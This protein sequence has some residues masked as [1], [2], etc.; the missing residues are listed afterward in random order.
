MTDHPN[1]NRRFYA[2]QSPRGFANEVMIRVFTTRQLRDVWVS[3]HQDDGDV[4][5]AGC[6]AYVITSRAARDI[7]GYRGDAVTQSYN[8]AVDH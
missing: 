2:A 1:R 8:A 5:S 7:L 4:N 3:A 6:G